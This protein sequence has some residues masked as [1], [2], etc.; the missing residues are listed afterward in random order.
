MSLCVNFVSIDKL[1]SQKTPFS[2]IIQLFTKKN[3]FYCKSH[4]IK[5]EKE[6][7]RRKL[8]LIKCYEAKRLQAGYAKTGQYIYTVEKGRKHIYVYSSIQ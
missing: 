1:N 2:S 7:K 3:A 5:K 6:K 8:Q 4:K